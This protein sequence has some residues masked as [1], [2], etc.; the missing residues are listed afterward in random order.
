M[1]PA[2]IAC[3]DLAK[4][5]GS[6]TVLDEV[7]GLVIPKDLAKAFRQHKGASKYFQALPKSKQKMM[8][9]WVVLAKLPETRQ[10]RILEI[11]ALAA[12]QKRPK[13]FY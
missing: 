6:W 5:N 3:I 10:R 13:Q 2:G 9:Q 11:A 7:E 1:A 8:L 4:Q 12:E